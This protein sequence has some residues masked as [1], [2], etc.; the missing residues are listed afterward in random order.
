[1]TKLTSAQIN[2]FEKEGYLVV[3][4]LFDPV[5]DLDPIIEEYT[6]VL[7]RLASE[8]YAKGII[9]STHAG[10]PFG[11][12]FIRISLEGKKTFS[13]HFDFSLPQKGIREDTPMWVGPAVFRMLRT[14]RLL[15]AV[16]NIIGPEI[17]SNP[18]QHV[19]LKLP[20][21]RTVRDAT[22]GNADAA[23]PWHQDNGVVL[24]D[25]DETDILTVWFPLWDAPVEAGCLQVLPRSHKRG[26]LDHC[27][28]QPTGA[29]RIPEKILIEPNRTKAIGV[30]LKRGDALFMHRLTCHAAL[31]N[32]SNNMRGS[33]DLRYNP[34][35]QT[36]GRGAFPGFVAR[37]RAHPETELHDAKAWAQMWHDARQAL[38]KASEPA[39]FNRWDP[40][41]S[42]CA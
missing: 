9:S 21:G 5:K 6:G 24:P 27:P 18:V 30:P 8:L 40:K 10:Q 32:I 36:T 1:M 20:E 35:G 17:Y 12:R 19:R 7:D 41:A 26:L 29:L 31:P 25:A 13:Q 28:L 3:E 22:G 34:I 33:M 15:N 39:R 38:A 16:E 37:S 23:T 14:E 2:H 11:E 4:G 42:V